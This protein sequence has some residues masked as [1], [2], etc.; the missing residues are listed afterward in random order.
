MAVQG[1]P[2]ESFWECYEAIGE[3]FDAAQLDLVRLENADPLFRRE[4]MQGGVLLAGD[5]ADLFALEETHLRKKMAR[6][7]KQLHDSA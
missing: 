7:K 4:I 1:W 5:S 3:A 6:L 2:G